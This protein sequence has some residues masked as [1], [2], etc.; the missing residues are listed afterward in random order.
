M[1]RKDVWIFAGAVTFVGA[2][3]GCG[4]MSKVGG[5][6]GN[7]QLAKDVVETAGKATECEKLRD[8]QIAYDEEV[9]LGGAVAVNVVGGHGGLLIGDQGSPEHALTRYVNMVGKNLAA[10]SSRPTLDW[11]FGVLNS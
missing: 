4:V 11:T 8:L 9:A 5:G 1:M 3:I 7:L 6:R 2:V 10:Q